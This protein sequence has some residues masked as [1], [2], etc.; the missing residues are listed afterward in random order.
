MVEVVVVHRMVYQVVL[1]VVLDKGTQLVEQ[2][3]YLHIVHLKEILVLVVFLVKEVVEVVELVLLV[4]IL[5][6][7]LV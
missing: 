1:V 3:I 5:L 7:V 4:V 6:E 2:V